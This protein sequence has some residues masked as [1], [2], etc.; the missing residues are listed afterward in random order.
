MFRRPSRDSFD[1]LKVYFEIID[2]SRLYERHRIYRYEEKEKEGKEGR[3]GGREGL[4]VF[5]CPDIPR[6][7]HKSRVTRR[8][9]LPRQ[10]STSLRY[11]LH[12]ITISKA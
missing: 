8:S 4:L 7:S 10:K 12:L 11:G 2:S 3:K 1:G 6:S 9:R 5:E